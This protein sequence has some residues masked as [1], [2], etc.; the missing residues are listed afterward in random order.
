MKHCAA[1]MYKKKYEYCR[2]VTNCIMHAP[3]RLLDYTDNTIRSIMHGLLTTHFTPH[4]SAS[5]EYTQCLTTD[6][7]AR[8][9]CDFAYRWAVWWKT[10]INYPS[11]LL[12]RT[13]FRN[14]ERDAMCCTECPYHH[15][16]RYIRL[17]SRQPADSTC[18]ANSLLPRFPICTIINKITRLWLSTMD[19]NTEKYT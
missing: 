15:Q 3:Q 4:R 6:K 17:I 11:L 5:Q 13:L 10:Q 19:N 1:L 16:V 2:Q 9:E 12:F 18:A 8:P 14:C 7:I